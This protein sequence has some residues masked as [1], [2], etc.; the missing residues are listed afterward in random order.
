M[1][2]LDIFLLLIAV[3]VGTDITKEIFNIKRTSISD[4]EAERFFNN[5]LIQENENNKAFKT[6][7]LALAKR[8]NEKKFTLIPQS[9]LCGLGLS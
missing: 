6:S 1:T 5:L 4:K 8:K 2:S 3:I 9:K 7:G